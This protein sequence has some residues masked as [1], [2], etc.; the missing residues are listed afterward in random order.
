MASV[1]NKDIPEEYEFFG[2]YFTFRKKFYTPEI[3]QDYWNALIN[4]ANEL[5]E[6]YNRNDYLGGL[7]LTCIDDLEHRY[8]R[9]EGRELEHSIVENVYNGI[10]QKRKEAKR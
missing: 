8:A 10:M 3:S 5:I 4:D 6:K 2:E 1:K 7:V 9:M